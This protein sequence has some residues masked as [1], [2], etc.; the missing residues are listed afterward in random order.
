[1][2]KNSLEKH[3]VKKHFNR[4]AYQ[5]DNHSRV[6]K[7]I[8]D[9]LMVNFPYSISPERILDV[10]CG[11]GYLTEKLLHLF[12]TSTIV[13]LDMTPNMLRVANNKF[14]GINRLKWVE[15][16]IEQ[17]PCTELIR[18]GHFDLI[19]SS[20]AFQWLA[21]PL[22]TLQKL[23]QALN[24]SGTIAFATLGKETFKEL[25]QAFGLANPKAE[26]GYQHGLEM[27]DYYWWRDA[28]NNLFIDIR[29]EKRSYQTLYPSTLEFLNSIK[30]IGANNAAPGDK[31]CH[32][33][34]VVKR[35][36]KIYEECFR[37]DD[38]VYATYEAL[39][40]YGKTSKEK[41]LPSLQNESDNVKINP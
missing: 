11:T 17:I 41:I 23:S 10:G 31:Q 21:Y 4:Q 37:K 2:K 5:Y 9:T 33:P 6:Q 27:P 35:M 14:P 25:H 16:D 3:L 12:P 29:T 7:E 26:N 24:A 20:T 13:A 22:L 15:A 32:N 1:M 34:G 19:V 39:F 30:Y 40:F 28:V 38:Q 8:A 18:E 36:I